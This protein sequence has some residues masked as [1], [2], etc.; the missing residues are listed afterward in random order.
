MNCFFAFFF[1]LGLAM[2]LLLYQRTPHCER[3]QERIA[4]TLTQ[5]IPNKTAET[6][7]DVTYQDGFRMWSGTTGTKQFKAKI[8][9]FQGDSQVRI[10]S[11]EGKVVTAPIKQFCA[12]DQELIRKMQAEQVLPE[13]FREWADVSGTKK[14]VAKLLG[15]QEGKALFELQDGRK[16]TARIEQFEEK[17]LLSRLMDETIPST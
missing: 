16:I 7:A 8:V 2:G 9:G 5:Y 1:P 4:K 17:E 10:Q 13:G 12:A 3:L 11:P 6:E 14:I 15:F